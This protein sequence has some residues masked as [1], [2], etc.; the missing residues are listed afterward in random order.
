MNYADI[1]AVLDWED[2]CDKENNNEQATGKKE[3]DEVCQ[4]Q[5]C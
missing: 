5:Y 3:N 2:K 1:I 4:K